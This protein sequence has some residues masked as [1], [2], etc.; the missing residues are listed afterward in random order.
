MLENNFTRYNFHV[1]VN[2]DKITLTHDHLCSLFMIYISILDHGVLIV[3]NYAFKP[4]SYIYTIGTYMVTCF[5]SKNE[6]KSILS[7]TGFSYFLILF[8]F[9]VKTLNCILIFEDP[10][11]K[12]QSS[13]TSYY[14]ISN[15][16][17]PYSLWL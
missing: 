8:L 6:S 7:V 1:W 17:G 15:F 13:C 11:A 5:Y 9:I 2:T 16:T 4:V 10:F 3:L 12:C 14:Y